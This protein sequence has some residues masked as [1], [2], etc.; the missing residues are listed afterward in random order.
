MMVPGGISLLAPTWPV[1]RD[2]D[3]A[4]ALVPC[5]SAAGLWGVRHP[6]YLR[7][8]IKSRKLSQP[9]E[10]VARVSRQKF[11]AGGGCH[12]LLSSPCPASRSD[13][14]SQHP[15]VGN[16]TPKETGQTHCWRSHF[17]KPAGGRVRTAGRLDR[18]PSPDVWEPPSGGGAGDSGRE[19]AASPPSSLR[20]AETGD[21]HPTQVRAGA[22][23]HPRPRC[24]R[25]R[26]DS[27]GPSPPPPHPV[28]ERLPVWTSL[29]S[30]SAKSPGPCSA[31]S[32][33]AKEK[34]TIIWA[35]V[36]VQITNSTKK[37]VAE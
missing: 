28:A 26:L 31:E 16:S 11:L 6:P 23:P 5:R 3:A 2:R 10:A 29:D 17:C 15:A 25:R 1:P 4:S 12:L 18:H 32:G 30:A 35:G 8:F 13:T 14:P 37:S 27:P 22:G 24:G 7:A 9:N 36:G 19:L 34:K 33:T 20:F 21:G